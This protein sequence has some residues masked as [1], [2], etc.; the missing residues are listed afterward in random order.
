MHQLDQTVVRGTGNGRLS[1]PNLNLIESA[2]AKIET[3]QAVLKQDRQRG[4]AM[5]N[6]LFRAGTPPDPPLDGRYA[7]KLVALDIAP[8]L[9]QLMGLV[10]NAWL[11]WQGKTFNAAQTRGD[12][13]FTRD[14]LVLAHIYWPL[15][16]G[17]I[18]DG[19]QTYRAFAFR[20][21]IA[22]GLADPDR[23]VLKIDY[24]QPGNPRLSIRRI[25]DE[26]VQVEDGF[27]LG[28]A[29]LKWW[30]GTWQLVAYFSL[31]KG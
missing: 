18:D 17:Y 28:K 2:E 27:Y 1:T 19:S 4:L 25:L 31:R 21:T 8:G 6:D 11:P 7:G 22:P 15:Y 30:W 26:L 16:R 10:V 24:D 20:T 9:T 29:H 3:A 14:S 23:Q 13:I 5:L 12:N